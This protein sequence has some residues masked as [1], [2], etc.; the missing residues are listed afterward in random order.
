VGESFIRPSIFSPN[1]TVDPEGFDGE[2]TFDIENDLVI[3]F[4]RT[5]LVDDILSVTED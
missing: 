3:L 5:I 2:P 1:L 4:D